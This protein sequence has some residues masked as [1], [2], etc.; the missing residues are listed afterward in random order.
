LDVF[1]GAKFTF[2]AHYR[3]QHEENVIDG[4]RRDAIEPGSPA[5]LQ[6]Q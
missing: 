2:V 5:L 4:D 1:A 6:L 3:A